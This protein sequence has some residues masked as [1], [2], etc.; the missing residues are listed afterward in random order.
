MKKE[1]IEEDE[2]YARQE[3]KD[4]AAKIAHHFGWDSKKVDAVFED[5]KE[6]LTEYNDQLDVY[7]KAQQGSLLLGACLALLAISGICNNNNADLSIKTLLSAS[8]FLGVGG[9][10][11][12]NLLRKKECQKIEHLV[13]E[14]E[15][16]PQKLNEHPS[17]QAT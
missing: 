3:F 6:L 10:I 2:Y 15:A 5:R 16:S 17:P 7:D 1:D 11:I 12:P 13:A 14:I 4:A 9:T 8:A